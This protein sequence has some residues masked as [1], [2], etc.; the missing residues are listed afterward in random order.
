MTNLAL[1]Q[2]KVGKTS[3]D[4]L[5]TIIAGSKFLLSEY[6]FCLLLVALNCCVGFSQGQEPR[7]FNSAAAEKNWQGVLQS[8][9]PPPIPLFYKV[10]WMFRNPTSKEMTELYRSVYFP[11]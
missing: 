4:G 8:S 10:K 6:F 5:F 11:A 7:R 1:P 2:S 9:E 3:E